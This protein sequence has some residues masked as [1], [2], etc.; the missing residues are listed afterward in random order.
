MGCCYSSRGCRSSCCWHCASSLYNN[1]LLVLGCVI[2]R[3]QQDFRGRGFENRI[4][5]SKAL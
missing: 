5:K 1:L 3:G 2:V 4:Q